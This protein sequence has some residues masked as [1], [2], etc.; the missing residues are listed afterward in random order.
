VSATCPHELLKKDLNNSMY[1]RETR[2][3]SKEN[4]CPVQQG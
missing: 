1:S 4:P 3:C 2:A